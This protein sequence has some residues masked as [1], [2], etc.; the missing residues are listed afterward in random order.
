[1]NDA[2][3]DAAMLAAHESNDLE[4]LVAFY[5]KAGL[6]RIATNDVDAGCFYLT[7]AYIFALEAG[8]S[9]AKEIHR[10]LVAYGREE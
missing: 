2:V 8:M 5:Q 4:Q 9:Q 10:T 1:M 7:H 3:L 6:S